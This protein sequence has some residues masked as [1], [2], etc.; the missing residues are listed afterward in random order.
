MSMP[1]R[2]IVI[3]NNFEDSI[4]VLSSQIP[5]KTEPVMVTAICRPSPEK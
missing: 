5:K 4:N 3:V 1:K 2:E